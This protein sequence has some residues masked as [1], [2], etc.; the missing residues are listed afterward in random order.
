M[1]TNMIDVI[2]WLNYRSMHALC[3]FFVVFGYGCYS[4]GSEDFGCGLE[5]Y[6][7]FLLLSGYGI[8]GFATPSV[9]TLM[10]LFMLAC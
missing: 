1:G 7:L 9:L 4:I 3:S 6:F 5:G 2:M 10:V 8:L